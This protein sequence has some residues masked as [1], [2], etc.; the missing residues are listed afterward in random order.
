MA[1]QD[2][3]SNVRRCF[4]QPL[5]QYDSTTAY[6]KKCDPPHGLICDVAKQEM[7]TSLDETLS[8]RGCVKSPDHFTLHTTPK[9]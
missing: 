8:L 4:R 9:R 5:T 7:G 1:L 2:A 3:L 6:F